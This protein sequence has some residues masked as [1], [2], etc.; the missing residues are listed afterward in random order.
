LKK[1]KSSGSIILLLLLLVIS[2]NAQEKGQIGLVIGYPASVG[3]RWN[4]GGNFA[5]RPDVAFTKSSGVSTFSFSQESYSFETGLSAL[6]YVKKWENVSAY[7]TPRISYIRS[8]SNNG[9]FVGASVPGVNWSYLGS[10]SFGAEY[11]LNRK[12]S[13]FGEVGV[14]Y[15]RFHSGSTFSVT[16]L[17]KTW[18]SKSGVGINLYF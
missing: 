7:V 17:T 6:L 12:F 16:P 3:F 8:K 14:A 9:A 4:V 15:T 10:A 18:N 13:V 1:A 11:N 5:I 2:A